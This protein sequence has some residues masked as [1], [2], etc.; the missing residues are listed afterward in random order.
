MSISSDFPEMSGLRCFAVAARHLNFTSAAQE[1]HITQSAV[2]HRIRR[3]EAS[4]GF[5]LFKRFTRRLALTDEGARLFAVLDGALADIEMEIRNIQLRELAG[6]LNIS[7]T[8]TFASYW[9]IP[10]LPAF[11]DR[12]PGI[13]LNLSIRNGLV[14]F[15]SEHVD[16]AFYYGHGDYP[17]LHVTTLMDE[18]LVPVCTRR[19]A[20]EFNLWDNP[21]GL[22]ECLILYDAVPWPGAIHSSEWDLWAEHAGI[23]PL[24][25]DNAY[26]FDSLELAMQT[27]LTG[28]GVAIGRKRMVQQLLATGRLAAPFNI[29]CPLPLGYHAVSSPDRTHTSRLKAVLEW[30][31]E[32]AATD[33]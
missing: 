31:K 14:D 27:A 6:P 13:R 28:R 30:L 11:N 29:S 26:T 18:E 16:L 3:L 21:A 33:K 1:L 15:R 2:S 8:L 10:R 23:G 4:L 22:R 32:E 20:D 17:G 25:F 24:C 5:P 7:A 9:L 19:Y 12:F